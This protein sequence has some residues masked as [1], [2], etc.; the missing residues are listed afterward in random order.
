VGCVHEWRQARGG[1]KS[2]VAAVQGASSLVRDPEALA[3]VLHTRCRSQRF[4]CRG[5]PRPCFLLLV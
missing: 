3:L 1:A 2:A 4:A 5:P